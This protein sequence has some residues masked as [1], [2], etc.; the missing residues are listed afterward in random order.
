MK[1]HKYLNLFNVSVKNKK[2][3]VKSNLIKKNTIVLKYL[4]KSNLIKNVSNDYINLSFYNN[5]PKFKKISI[6]KH[7][8]YKYNIR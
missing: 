1:A 8:G 2:N 6:S 5:T 7:N 4:L 3:V